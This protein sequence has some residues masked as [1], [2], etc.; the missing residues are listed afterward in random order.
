[1]AIG[2]QDPGGKHKRAVGGALGWSMPDGQYLRGRR[3]MES[4]PDSDPA[5]DLDGIYSNRAVGMRVIGIEIVN[6]FCV[7]T[8]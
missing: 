8:R 7:S 1:M 3:Y 2:L 5:L 6:V 4:D